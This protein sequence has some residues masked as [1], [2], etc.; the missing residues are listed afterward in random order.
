MRAAKRAFS[1]FWR[2]PGGGG[3]VLSLAYP[4]ILSNISYTFET[5]LD[6]VF[7]S[8]YSKEAMAGA[9]AGMLVLWV[10]IGLFVYT[11]EY[12][13]TFV[14]Q[15]FGAGRRE[16]I[17]PALWQGLYFSLLAGLL[18]AS[19]SPLAQP[20]FALAGHAP[21]V[22]QAEVRYT[23]I[24]MLGA[25]PA[26]AMA[27]LSTF[28][29]GRGTTRSVLLVNLFSAVLDTVL[30]WCWI[31]GHAGFPRAGVAGAAYSTIV[32]QAAGALA[33]VVLILRRDHRKAYATLS[34]WR[35]EPRLLWRL[36]RFGLPSG[37]TVSLEVLAFALFLV[38]VGRLG[39]D[40]LAATTIAF[41][42]NALIFMP[43]LGLGIG[44][45]SLVGRYLGA[46]RP[47]L[48]ERA[49]WS[50]FW[51][52][53]AY[54]GACGLVFLLAPGPL[55]APFGGSAP[56]AGFADVPAVAAVLLRFVVVYSIFDMMNV[57]F[58]AGL[59]GA[60]DTGYPL[61][62]TVGL[63]WGAMLVPGY[64]ACMVLGGGVYTAWCFASAYVVLLGLLMLRRFRAGRWKALRVIEPHVPELDAGLAGA[65]EA[66]PA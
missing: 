22:Q 54:M 2:G 57:V 52:S 21:G 44:V 65:P 53:L 32:S 10:F 62:L 50:A 56:G 41:T 23:R 63:S 1:D 34:G 13:T 5:F 48:A 37:L 12:L 39:T 31:F 51:M 3:E 18:V 35:L 28:F 11:G 49:T 33:Y 43:M 9:H 17:G 46:E 19:L 26:V 4:L 64:V 29:S 47:A 45:S 58:A 55:L 60:G 14:A 24:M 42:L 20:L 27:T 25:F 66:E 36:V 16:R 8:H 38:I 15:Y 7:L 30:N 6:R 61:A 40:E 59:K